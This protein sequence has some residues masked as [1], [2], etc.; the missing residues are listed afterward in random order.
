M[1]VPAS[2]FAPRLIVSPVSV[3]APLEVVRLALTLMVSAERMMA[4]AL[5]VLMA[6]VML[7]TSVPP[8]P[9]LLK[10]LIS[11]SLPRPPRRVSSPPP[12]VST[13]LKPSPVNV[14]SPDE[15]IT[16]S[17][18]LSEARPVAVGVAR[19]TLML[20]ECPA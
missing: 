1:F 16:F 19:L 9:S 17:M 6:D 18:S 20:A 5:P 14:S 3:I 7:M 13:L 10:P 11:V 8:S 12:P 15:P 4:V 2:R